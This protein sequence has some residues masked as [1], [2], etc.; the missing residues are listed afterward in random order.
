VI[1]AVLLVALAAAGIWLRPGWTGAFTDAGVLAGLAAMVGGGILA[2]RGV[3]DLGGSLTA[4]PHPKDDGALVEFGVF[5]LVRHPIY[6]GLILG[7]LGWSLLQ[8]SF[9][10]LILTAAI[11]V[12]FTLKATVEEAWLTARFEGYA[13]YRTRTRRFIPWIY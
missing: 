4:L 10:A 13:A 7:S 1:Q 6:G 8:A 2:F 9:A 3:K 12:F 5:R 11:A